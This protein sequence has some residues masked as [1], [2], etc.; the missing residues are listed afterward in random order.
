MKQTR[1]TFL[2]FKQREREGVR[3]KVRDYAA[4]IL[5]PSALKLQTPLKSQVA[6]TSE[7]ETF[8]LELKL[9]INKP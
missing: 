4:L 5:P 1:N 6:N 3:E 2:N 7:D 8:L 9:K